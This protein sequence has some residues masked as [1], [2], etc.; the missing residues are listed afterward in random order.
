MSDAEIFAMQG[1]KYQCT[2]CN[3]IIFPTVTKVT[4]APVV[5][6]N[7]FGPVIPRARKRDEV[8]QM[9]LKHFSSEELS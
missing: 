5:D 3:Q 4:G 6:K 9:F 8:E 2:K 1:G 7:K